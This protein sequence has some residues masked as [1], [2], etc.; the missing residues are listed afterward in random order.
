MIK[1][2]LTF[3]ELPGA[4]VDI[5]ERLLNI[6]NILSQKS[7]P[8]LKDELLTIEQAADFLSLSKFTVYTLVNQRQI[9]FMKKSKRLYF[10]KDELLTW[11]KS[12]TRKPKL[13]TA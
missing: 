6:E 5:S 11:L 10:S 9:P 2:T 4:I 8:E 3:N 12:S 1:Q 13:Q 7:S